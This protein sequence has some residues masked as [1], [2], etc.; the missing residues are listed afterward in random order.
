MALSTEQSEAMSI[1]VSSPF[2]YILPSDINS[3]KFLSPESF[4]NQ[5]QIRGVLASVSIG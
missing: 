5:T 4:V 3:K 1:A 2:T